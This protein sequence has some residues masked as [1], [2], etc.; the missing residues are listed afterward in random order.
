M[1]V[2]DSE[3]ET[4]SSAL[5]SAELRD[6]IRAHHTAFETIVHRETHH[7]LACVIGYDLILTA[8]PDGPPPLDP[9]DDRCYGV[10]ARLSQVAEEVLPKRRDEHLTVDSFEPALHLRRDDGWSP[11]IQL[12]VEIRHRASDYFAPT[13]NVERSELRD[14]QARLESW[15]VHKTGGV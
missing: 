5:P 12:V 1:P 3:I 10:F 14:L 13:D 4:K 7:G 9:G 6:W 2:A 8:I 11:A 15:G